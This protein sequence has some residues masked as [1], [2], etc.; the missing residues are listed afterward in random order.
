M[1]REALGK[2]AAAPPLLSDPRF[3]D[4]VRRRRAFTW[5]LT[6]AML[7]I[8]FTFI[9][10]LAFSPRLLGQPIVQGQPATWGIP[11]GFGMFAVTFALVAIY[12]FQANSVYDAIV[13]AIRLGDDR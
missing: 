10:T 11:V 5:S 2:V 4:L 9:L 6:T 13:A 3:L 1:N 7:A 8:Y 12:V